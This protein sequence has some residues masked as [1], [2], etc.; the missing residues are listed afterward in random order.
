[1][2]DDTFDVQRAK[3]RSAPNPHAAVRDATDPESL[4]RLRNAIARE[5]A[6]G[7]TATDRLCVEVAGA[8]AKTID[9]LTDA[10]VRVRVCLEDF[11][12]EMV[13]RVLK[14]MSRQGGRAPEMLRACGH[15]A[16]SRAHGMI[17]GKVGRGM[18]D[19]EAQLFAALLQAGALALSA[20]QIQTDG[21]LCAD[22]S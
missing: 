22:G 10:Q 18:D 7:L 14:A 12:D 21:A 4:G 2:R 1:M 17:G 11:A 13:T 15:E 5:I 19:N 9:E 16:L 6:E 8:N 20:A 3:N